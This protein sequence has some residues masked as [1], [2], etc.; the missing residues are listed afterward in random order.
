MNASSDPQETERRDAL[1]NAYCTV[2]S[3]LEEEV[4]KYRRLE[5]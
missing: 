2:R 4:S 1:V 5:Y 3:I